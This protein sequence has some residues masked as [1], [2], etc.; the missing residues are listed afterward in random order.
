MT[1]ESIVSQRAGKR[2]N[3]EKQ[4]AETND[5]L[6]KVIME[7]IA[8]IRRRR[9]REGCGFLSCTYAPVAL[10]KRA[11]GQF[12]VCSKAGATGGSY[13]E[14]DTGILGADPD[15]ANNVSYY[16]TISSPITS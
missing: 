12:W 1:R 9:V 15:Q 11:N 8:E 4:D 2:S 13:E 10:V 3:K 5:G 6:P 7:Y 14:V 16:S